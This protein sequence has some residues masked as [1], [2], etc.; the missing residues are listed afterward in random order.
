VTGIRERLKD[1]GK[2]G[3]PNI[4][5][6]NPMKILLPP[7]YINHKLIK[8]LVKAM[9]N[10]NPKGFKYLSNKFPN[11]NSAALKEGLFVGLSVREILG[12]MIDT[13]RAAWKSLKWD[14]SISLCRK[15]SP[16]F[17]N[18]IYTLLNAHT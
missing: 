6:V 9:A 2:D 16:G 17:S 5:P 3:V 4:P 1:L 8:C 15:I 10:T 13:K 11:I 7:R 18:G 12:S 14:F